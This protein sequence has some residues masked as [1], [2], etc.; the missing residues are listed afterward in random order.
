[1]HWCLLRASAFNIDI[2]SA[3]LAEVSYRIRLI[4]L[5]SQMHDCESLCRRSRPG[6]GP[7]VLDEEPDESCVALKCCDM[8]C[9]RSGFS[10]AWE[11]SVDCCTGFGEWRGSRDLLVVKGQWGFRVG[12][13]CA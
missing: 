7:E 12:G 9:C 6:T 5:G 2:K 11:V 8:E 1:V 4:S 10:S 3:F 13:S